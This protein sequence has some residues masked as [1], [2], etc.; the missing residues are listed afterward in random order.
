MWNL[1]TGR[2]T[3]SLHGHCLLALSPDGRLFTDGAGIWDVATGA[4]KHALTSQNPLPVESAPGSSPIPGVPDY[5]EAAAFS[6][7]GNKVA[8]AASNERG[9]TLTEFECST[10]RESWSPADDQ[11]ESYSVAFSP[12]GELLAAGRIRAGED[13]GLVKVWNAETHSAGRGFFTSQVAFH[14][15]RLQSGQPAD[16]LSQF[17]RL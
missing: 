14:T 12:N 4:L 8:I 11:E 1:P 2:K 13:A 5:V 6:P 15:F 16:R 17:H 9:K 3:G 10:G 7:D